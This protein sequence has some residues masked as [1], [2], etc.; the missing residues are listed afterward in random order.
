M[1]LITIV[2][3]VFA[4]NL[5]LHADPMVGRELNISGFTEQGPVSLNLTEIYGDGADTKVSWRLSGL[6]DEGRNVEAP[7]AEAI[8]KASEKFIRGFEPS[9]DSKAPISQTN[10]S[11]IYAQKGF[12]RVSLQWGKGSNLF[13]AFYA[14]DS[15]KANAEFGLLMQGIAKLAGEESVVGLKQLSDK[16]RN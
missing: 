14:S 11:A 15:R 9:R 8:L 1:K 2:F 4:L 3:S 16:W 5:P 10:S 6:A 13:A 7:V 12:L